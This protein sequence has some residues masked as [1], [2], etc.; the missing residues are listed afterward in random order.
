MSWS[1]MGVKGLI[2]FLYSHCLSA[3][4][5][6]ST[7]GKILLWSFRNCGSVVYMF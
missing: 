3:S 6:I 1:L 5:H 4:Y 7:V 2:F